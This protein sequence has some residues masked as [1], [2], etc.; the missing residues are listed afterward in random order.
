MGINSKYFLIP[1][2]IAPDGTVFSIIPAKRYNINKKKKK[3]YFTGMFNF[4]FNPRERHIYKE[5]RHDK[6]NGSKVIA[7]GIRCNLKER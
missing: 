4:L 2:N 7:L 3:R 6:S 1:A 5:I